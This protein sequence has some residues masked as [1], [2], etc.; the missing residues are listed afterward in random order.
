MNY[1]EHIFLG[2]RTSDMTLAKQECEALIGGKLKCT[3]ST[4][5]GGDHCHVSLADS[6][7]DLRLNYHDDGDGYSWCVENARS[8]MTAG[9]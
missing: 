3:N 6:Y 8:E 7:Y 5:Y 1:H 4:F 9:P 2:V